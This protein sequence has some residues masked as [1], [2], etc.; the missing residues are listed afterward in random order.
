MFRFPAVAQ[1]LLNTK[2]YSQCL[3]QGF[4]ISVHFWIILLL[5]VPQIGSL[6]DT[7]ALLSIE[8]K[9]QMYFIA[10]LIHRR[11]TRGGHGPPTFHDQSHPL[12]AYAL[13]EADLTCLYELIDSKLNCF[14]H[15]FCCQQLL[16]PLQ[17]FPLLLLGKFSEVNASSRTRFP[18][19][20]YY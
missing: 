19:I 12:S 11:R 1:L 15:Y 10:L 8:L 17:S 7:P 2:V 6:L 18:L 9:Q 5:E 13:E 14:H 16:S 20:I 4:L 3:V